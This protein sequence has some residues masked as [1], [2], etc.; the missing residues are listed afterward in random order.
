M[1]KIVEKAKQVW[2]GNTYMTG[3]FQEIDSQ[4][5]SLK[6]EIQDL[7]KDFGKA[8]ELHEMVDK[9]RKLEP[10]DTLP[11]E[12]WERGDVVSY[13]DE[14]EKVWGFFHH[15]DKNEVWAYWQDINRG[16][17]KDLGYMPKI[18]ITKVTFEFRPEK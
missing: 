17:R 5:E 18:K 14:D 6:Q 9:I 11:P 7:R 12:Q 3:I 1:G 16:F 2:G 8:I 15:L 4:F 10:Q 13:I